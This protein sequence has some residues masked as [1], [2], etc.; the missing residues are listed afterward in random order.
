[1]IFI[2][3]DTHS[4][5]DI[6]KLSNKK[7]PIGAT[8]TR[9]DYVII[10][11]DFGFIWNGSKEEKWWLKWFGDKNYTI[12]FVDG[13]HENFELLNSY[14]IEIWNG[15]KV[16][17][18]TENIIHLMRGQVFNIN[19]KKIFTFGG[20]TSI[21]KERRT[22]HISW[23]SEELP[24]TAE[25]NEGIDNL[26]K[27]NWEVDYVIT[28]CCSGNTLRTVSAYGGFKYD[29]EM[30]ILNKYFDHIE[31]KLEYK[32]WYFGH[33]HLDIN[34]ILNNQTVIY[35]KVIDIENNEDV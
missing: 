17:K 19:G 27:N 16:H 5:I 4:N 23:W 9:N 3:G 24:T 13:N 20:A 15:G 35:Q 33:Y 28:H 6:K 2:T 14:P 12:L 32:H 22:K 30:D 1:M 34:Y 7:F 26:E 25:L 31:E 21:D 18:I 8:L 10:A 29:Y 11:G